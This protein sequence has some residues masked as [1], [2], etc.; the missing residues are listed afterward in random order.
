MGIES[1]LSRRANQPE[2][3]ETARGNLP[4]Q[5]KPTA[6]AGCTPET[7]ETWHFDKS[8][9]QSSGAVTC[10]DCRHA[11]PAA[12]HTMMVACGRGV[13]SGNPTRHYWATD[14]HACDAFDEKAPGPSPKRASRVVGTTFHF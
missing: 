8:G 2:T 14:T 12:F 4:F 5:P 1:L 9:T 11:I 7:C 6:G 13:E 3:S 10:A